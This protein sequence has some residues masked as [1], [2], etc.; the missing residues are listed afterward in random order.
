MP[1]TSQIMLCLAA[2]SME[3]RHSKEYADTQAFMP[4]DQTCQFS[5]KSDYGNSSTAH[6]SKHSSLKKQQHRQIINTV[7]IYE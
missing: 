7:S 2:I 4:L 1:L 6:P 5:T 3:L